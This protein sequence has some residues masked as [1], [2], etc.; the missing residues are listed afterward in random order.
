[1]VGRQHEEWKRHGPVPRLLVAEEAGPRARI[2]RIMEPRE[3]RRARTP[4][5][6]MP[7]RPSVEFRATVKTRG[8][9]PKIDE[10]ISTK[11]DELRRMQPAIDEIKVTAQVKDLGAKVGAGY[12]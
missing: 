6:E 3:W 7:M 4:K 9:S 2:M 10:V 5:K 12:E 1:M 11:Q 8:Q